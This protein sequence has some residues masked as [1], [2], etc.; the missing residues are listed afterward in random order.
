MQ[1][2]RRDPLAAL[3]FLWKLKHGHDTGKMFV[4]YINY[5]FSVFGHS[6]RPLTDISVT[7]SRAARYSLLLL[8]M[9]DLWRGGIIG[10]KERL[11]ISL[12]LKLLNSMITRYKLIYIF[13]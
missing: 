7:K 2:L 3:R 4:S 10:E 12:G 8:R 13:L 5:Y 1:E 9:D 6:I 11:C